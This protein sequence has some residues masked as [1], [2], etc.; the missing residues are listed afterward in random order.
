[1]SPVFNRS[2]I[3]G[4]VSHHDNSHTSTARKSLLTRWHHS[5]MWDTYFTVMRTSAAQHVY[6]QALGDIFHYFLPKRPRKRRW[7]PGDVQ[8][9]KSDA[10]YTAKRC[11]TSQRLNGNAFRS[12]PAFSDCHA[13][14]EGL[15]AG[16]SV[17][18]KD[19]SA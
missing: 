2:L 7:R 11:K 16:E 18:S 15:K 14:A 12:S 9:L 10:V 19:S 6:R 3:R 8:H 1:M 5:S 4:A 13:N 17:F